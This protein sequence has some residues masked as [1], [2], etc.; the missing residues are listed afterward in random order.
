MDLSREG[1]GGQV[2]IA[3]VSPHAGSCV[4]TVNTLRYADR[5][6]AIGKGGG[7]EARDAA[8]AERARRDVGGEG[9]RAEHARERA[10]REA[11]EEGRLGLF[12]AERDDHVQLG[13]SAQWPRAAPAPAAPATPGTPGTPGTASTPAWEARG[14]HGKPA[15][16]PVASPPPAAPR[17]ASPPGSAKG[18]GAESPPALQTRDG[19]AAERRGGDRYARAHATPPPA[20]APGAAGSRPAQARGAGR[21]RAFVKR[22][23]AETQTSMELVEQ[24]VRPNPALRP[25]SRRRARAR[26]G[27]TGARAGVP[28]KPKP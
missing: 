11:A 10:A 13:E 12:A 21:T 26:A 20:G 16:G 24:E 18:A 15:A 19:G 28:L 8:A 22:F 23:R 1:G 6:K 25:N 7:R 4:E 5:V 17:R 9:P 27:V 2:M 14:A 3:N